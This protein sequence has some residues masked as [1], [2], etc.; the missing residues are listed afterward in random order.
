LEQQDK[1]RAAVG[2]QAGNLATRIG[3]RE[4]NQKKALDKVVKAYGEEITKAMT[5]EFAKGVKEQDASAN[6]LQMF[7]PRVRA[8]KAVPAGLASGAVYGA[9]EQLRTGI[10]PKQI[11][12]ARQKLAEDKNKPDKK[13]LE[14]LAKIREELVKGVGDDYLARA[15]AQRLDIE[16]N[17]AYRGKGKRDDARSKFKGRFQGDVYNVLKAK[18]VEG[19]RAEEIANEANKFMDE[20]IQRQLIEQRTLGG[21][22]GREAEYEALR[23]RLLLK[24][25]Q[26]TSQ[27]PAGL[28]QQ[29]FGGAPMGGGNGFMSVPPTAAGA[30]AGAQQAQ[31]FTAYHQAAM[32]ALQ[33][34][35]AQAM[36]MQQILAAA[37]QQLEAFGM[38]TRN[39]W[40]AIQVQSYSYAPNH[41]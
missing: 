25:G 36:Q 4:T 12:E 39:Q 37:T 8:E 35:Q 40:R 24:S 31:G 27:Q 30:G 28:P 9:I 7:A 14:R 2:N 33:M 41:W 38:S 1:L 3:V 22:Q 23:N 34:Q 32:Q 21:P 19:G 18:G 5:E 29:G 17:D 15:E 20:D 16:V 11:D 6:V 13:E 10:T 26:Q